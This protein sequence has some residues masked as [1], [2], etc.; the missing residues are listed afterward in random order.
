MPRIPIL[1]NGTI[2]ASI[3][4]MPTLNCIK[5]FIPSPINPSKN[6]GVNISEGI[7][8]ISRIAKNKLNKGKSKMFAKMLIKEK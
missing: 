7:T 5:I 3:F 2:S 6:D 8:S 4:E 1:N